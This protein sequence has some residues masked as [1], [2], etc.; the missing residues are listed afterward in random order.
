[1]CSSEVNAGWLL[2]EATFAGKCVAQQCQQWQWQ[3]PVL[4][5]CCCGDGELSLLLLLTAAATKPETLI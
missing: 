2:C 3:L 5:G 4:A 1:M